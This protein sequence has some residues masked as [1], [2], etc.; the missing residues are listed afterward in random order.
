MNSTL[1]NLCVFSLGAFI[2]SLITWKLLKTKYEM[3]AQ[4]EI[5]S[6]KEVFSKRAKTV[7]L[8]DY[9]NFDEFDEDDNDEE[10]AET[11]HEDEQEESD[12]VIK[13][14]VKPNLADY[15]KMLDEIGYT[16]YS[17]I[18]TTTN[19]EEEGGNESMNTKKPY[20]ISPDEFGEL[21]EYEAVSLNYYADGVLTDDWDNVIEDVDG[22]VGKDSLTHFGEYEEDS[23]FVRN[24]NLK[25]DYEILMDV[26]NF[27]SVK[28][29]PS[30]WE[31]D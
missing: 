26:R 8:S 10:Y 24:D 28:H 14:G 23:V 11:E 22:I 30:E 18:T 15:A 1:K 29:Q 25:T 19:K 4:E 9:S 31:D 12:V 2:G 13:R 17:A 3:L 5:D 7:D 21:D 20:V 27:S 6:V 16:D